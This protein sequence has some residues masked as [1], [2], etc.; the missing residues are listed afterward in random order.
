MLKTHIQAQAPLRPA[1]RQHGM[2]M[3]EALAAIVI[4]MLGILGIAGLTAKSVTSAGHAQ[5]RT[6]A[7]MYAEQIVQ[8]ISLK[9]DRS[10]PTA[11]AAS[12]DAFKYQTGGSLCAFS[13]SSN[14]G[15]SSLDS[16]IGNVLKA[17][18]GQANVQQGV[19]Y[20]HGLPGAK[21][22]GQQIS[23]SRI[24]GVDQVKVTL[25]WQAPGDKAPRNYQLLAYVN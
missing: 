5:Y 18:L 21:A 25:C 17:A 23:V 11:L 19:A 4:V 6:E 1:H 7:G 9:V 15:S 13:G 14:G 20:V 2:M 12:L 16:E 8:M 24:N 10:S 3:I 22:A